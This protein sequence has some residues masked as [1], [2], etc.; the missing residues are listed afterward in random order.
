[1]KAITIKDIVATARGTE[2]LLPLL[3]G[4][5]DIRDW[6]R[7]IAMDSVTT[8][9]GREISAA[10]S[11]LNGAQFA[12]TNV[13]MALRSA[14]EL[15]HIPFT[16]AVQ[17]TNRVYN[18][19]DGL[20]SAFAGVRNEA[21]RELTVAE[22]T[23]SVKD[24]V[25]DE[26][27]SS[28]DAYTREELEELAREGSLSWESIDE[29][30][31][32]QEAK[33]ATGQSELMESDGSW[34]ESEGEF[35]TSV[36]T[37]SQLWD[38]ELTDIKF[39]ESSAAAVALINMQWPTEHPMWEPLLERLADSWESSIEYA[40]DKAAATKKVERREAALDDLH[41][42]PMMARWVINHVA[43]RVFRDM[44]MLELRAQDADDRLSVS[45]RQAMTEERY[46]VP[47]AMTRPGM[48][49]QPELE[50]KAFLFYRE[51]NE[52]EV[53]PPQPA[54]G[55]ERALLW[56]GTQLD[57]DR[58]WHGAV[59]EQ[60]R[61]IAD[62]LRSLYQQL[63]TMDLQLAKLWEIYASDT[64][65]AQPPLYWNMQGPIFDVA[66]AHAAIR[67]EANEAKQRARAAEGDALV[68]AAALVAEMLGL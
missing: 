31:D 25:F 13:A 21:H 66:E 54:G 18:M 33:Q 65:P 43:R 10:R 38:M 5:M 8:K 62:K 48:G 7:S 61:D 40:E 37:A 64:M 29:I 58:T 19:L 46:G 63:R 53:Q 49:E 22:V 26:L 57:L 51:L 52:A 2:I 68:K 23:L 60:A 44:A 56:H 16:R 14:T 50:R 42:K 32:M 1:M 55:D 35:R 3:S 28:S 9:A 67:V 59:A 47:G 12:M 36:H 30:M 6:A 20:R 4:E 24:G 34:S 11:A 27:Q 15:G 41:A 17:E 45:E 39:S